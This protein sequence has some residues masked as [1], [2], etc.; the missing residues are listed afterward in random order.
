ME[1]ITEIL[2]NEDCARKEQGVLSLNPTTILVEE[3]SRGIRNTLDMI[4]RVPTDGCSNFT[5]TSMKGCPSLYVGDI[6]IS[7]EEKV[8]R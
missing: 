4:E 5:E 2:T 7:L 3:Q 1:D 8:P 6:Y